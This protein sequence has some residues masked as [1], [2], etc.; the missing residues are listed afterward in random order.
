MM[1]NKQKRAFTDIEKAIL[2]DILAILSILL[3]GLAV[4]AYRS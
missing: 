4:N 3:N 1:T 2:T